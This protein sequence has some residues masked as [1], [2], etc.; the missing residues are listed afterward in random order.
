MT[1]A[2]RLRS[3]GDAPAL[4][5]DG[6]ALSY[7]ALAD[8]VD[9]LAALLDGGGTRRLVL[10]RGGNDAGAVT[11]YL[12]CLAARHP[13]L[14]AP[15]GAPLV[16]L[17]AAYDPDVVVD[18]DVVE[19]R[20]GSAHVLHEDLALL[21][22]T[23]GST[24]SPKLVRLSYENVES[25]A[26]AIAGYLGI[27]PDDRAA[28]TLPMHYC[29]GLSVLNS[30]LL[31]G[32]AVVLTDLSVVDACFWDLFRAHGATTFAGV[33]Y[34]FDLL[35]RAGFA[36]M[37]L[38]AL[39]YVTQAGGRLA[40]DRVRAY[41]E[42]G[43]RRGWD[44]WVMYGQT[45]AT[46]RMA[47]LPPDLA[48][49]HPG[50][51]GVPV[52]GGSFAI[53]DGELVYTG[54]NVM[55]G[56]AESP[57]DLALGRTVDR[58]RTGD[59]AR[60]ADGVYEVVGRRGRFVKAFGLRIDL[61]RVESLL[62][63]RGVVAA[64]ADDGEGL[65]VAVEGGHDVRDAV[66]RD[67]GLPPR[68]VR[69]RH[70]GTLPRLAGGK[71]DY[72]AVA[73]PG[74]PAPVSRAT[75]LRALYGEVL[76]R[77][78]VTDDDTFVS[79]GGDS[80][81]YV[82][83]SLRVEELL[84]HLPPSWH[85]TPIGALT[86]T[87]RRRGRR[88][89]TSVVMR[90]VAIVAIVG[91]H[92]NLLSLAGGAHLLLAVAGFNFARFHLAGE[93]RRGRHA[94]RTVARIAV[95][96]A[97]WMTAV[98]ATSDRYGL[99]NVLLLNNVLGPAALGPPWELWF[100]E[101][102]VYAVLAVTAL[103]RLPALARLER[104]APFGFAMGA[105]AVGVAMRYLPLRPGG[106]RLVSAH[107]VFWLFALGWATARATRVR[108]RLA[109]SAAALVTIPG[110]FPETSRTVIVAAG[111]LLL[112]WVP[113]VRWPA[114]LVR[115]TGVLASA[116]LY[117]YLT[118]WQVFPDLQWHSPALAT[119]LSFAVG[120][121]YWWVAT[122]GVA[123][124]RGTVARRRGPWR[125]IVHAWPSMRRTSVARTAVY[126]ARGHASPVIVRCATSV[127]T[128]PRPTIAMAEMTASSRRGPRSFDRARSSESAA[129]T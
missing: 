37:D 3:H 103:L 63:A 22:S 54:P 59:L 16:S 9:A 70:V 93:R 89:E 88:V 42:L 85:V 65:V 104:R 125:T 106:D 40:P 61:D 48:T 68:A 116:S 29:Y 53:E 119:A 28:T 69:V 46:A 74:A 81:S 76:E 79:L 71:V 8:R 34:T 39:R 57:A 110:F 60:E 17:V 100:L 67:C 111:V 45:E 51:V 91:T 99:P 6:G 25:N 96:T 126:P 30:H 107:V 127:S 117:V 62:A 113:T 66:A 12:A 115:P 36:D 77:D 114:R 95:P 11:A 124:V 80:L 102:F 1:F 84:G 78:G 97:V 49:T 50:A 41:A 13:V 94:L 109:V 20:P 35:D 83:L 15:P 5:W 101:V 23:S 2:D 26:D 120:L 56:Y 47:Y 82:E 21:L 86:A 55:L 64:C 92:A 44:L 24:G 90:A 118:H 38:P 105:V 10:V 31:A 75:S 98:V 122:S 121:A 73:A 18:G 43:R 58:L 27:R 52:P 128:T 7:A 108:H 19:R 14:L 4:L 129:A 72:V 87:T 33:P 112:V 32:A 123:H